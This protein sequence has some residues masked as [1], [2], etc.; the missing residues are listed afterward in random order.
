L[1]YYFLELLACPLCKTHPLKLYVIE[2]RESEEGPDP[3]SVK[4]KE[5]C[6]YLN[7]KADE[8]PIDVCKECVKKEVITGLLIC[9]RCG[10]WYPIVEGIPYMLPDEY[11][12]KRVDKEFIKRYW[13]S[14]PEDVKSLMKI[15]NPKEFLEE[16]PKPEP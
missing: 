10:R 16:K 7:K 8:V 13:S 1:R 2:E 11:R 14:L 3:A 12:I 6:G 5:Y 15:P 4:C 9:P